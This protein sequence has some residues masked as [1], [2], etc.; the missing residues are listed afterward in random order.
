MIVECSPYVCGLVWVFPLRLQTSVGMEKRPRKKMSIKMPKNPKV[1]NCRLRFD[2]YVCTARRSTVYTECIGWIPTILFVSL[3][4]TRYAPCWYV[5]K[6]CLEVSNHD[7][8]GK[9][10]DELLHMHRYLHVSSDILTNCP[11][12]WPV[13]TKETS[14]ALGLCSYYYH[15]WYTSCISFKQQMKGLRAVTR[16]RF[17]CCLPRTW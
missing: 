15:V 3:E 12:D 8:Q 10:L 5:R 1:K 17:L 6:K 14:V 9:Y 16:R 13:V 4:A 7:G 2:A 11:L